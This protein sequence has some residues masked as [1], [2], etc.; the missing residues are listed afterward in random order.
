MNILVILWVSKISMLMLMFTLGQKMMDIQIFNGRLSTAV[1]TTK[2]T[3]TF[4]CEVNELYN[5][6][7]I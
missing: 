3:S 1:M 2:I 4:L 7:Y 6:L 5:Y